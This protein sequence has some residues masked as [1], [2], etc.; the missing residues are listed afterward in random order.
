MAI[1]NSFYEYFAMSSATN[2]MY[3][4]SASSLVIVPFK[5]FQASHLY[6]P[7]MSNIPGRVVL[8]SPT[9]TCL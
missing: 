3:F 4:F 1:T 8:Q 7:L 6:F 5:L 2:A 9:V